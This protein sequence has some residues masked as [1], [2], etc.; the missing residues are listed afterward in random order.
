MV[1]LKLK[2]HQNEKNTL[3]DHGST[4]R[5]RNLNETERSAR[6]RNF[7][8]PKIYKIAAAANS[9]HVTCLMLLRSI[10]NYSEQSFLLSPG[11]FQE[12]WSVNHKSSSR[13]PAPVLQ[14]DNSRT[15]MTIVDLDVSETLQRG[16]LEPACKRWLKTCMASMVFS[17]VQCQL[18]QKGILS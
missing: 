15:W 17:N 2:R 9:H 6:N 3:T 14:V 5:H 16:V 13:L 10:S 11:P 18:C 7:D 12:P 1:L 8:A 4:H